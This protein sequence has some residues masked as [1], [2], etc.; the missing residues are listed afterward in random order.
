MRTGVSVNI[1]PR[2]ATTTGLAVEDAP[3]PAGAAGRGGQGGGG[4]GAQNVGRWHWDS[5]TIVSP[6]AARRLYFAGERVYRSDN[7]G[8]S[9]TAVSGD[10][11]RN[12]D[13][14][15]IPIMDKVWPADSVAYMEATTRLSTITALDE[16]PLLEGLLYAGTDDG[17]IHVSDDGGKTWRKV[18][19]ASLTAAGAPEFTY[20]TD[21]QA[22][23]RDVNTVFAALNDWNRGNFTP[24]LVKS[25]DR[26]RTWTSI[27]GDLPARSGAWSIVQDGVNGNL[28]FAGMEFGL[29]ATVDGGAHWIKMAGVPTSQVRD[30]AIQK[31]EGDLVAGTFGRGVFILDDYTALRDVTPQ[32]LGD[33]ARLYPMRDAYQY[34]ELG[35]FEASW[36]NTTYPSAP[37]GALMTYSI[38]QAPAGDTKV[39]IQIA[40]DQGKQVRRIELTGDAL[41][42]GLHRAA[43]DLRGDPPAGAAPGG[44]RGG[45][46]GGGG[47]GGRGNAG[48]T[49]AQARY[50]AT[51]GTISGDAFT[52]IGKP[53]SFLV[54]PLAR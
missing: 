40:D 34:N 16:S 7:R 1:R 8:D 35:Q 46:F 23:P 43:W 10:L 53:M 9:W 31:R 25:T 42:P 22:S 6:H 2:P 14:T 33:R 24:Y 29:Y 36:G 4:G 28:M 47:F 38:G 11:T 50:T 52:A 32:A 41:T 17:L 49:V 12:L 18:E 37:Y 44:G 30:I 39:A 13:R 21:L 15:K 48:P 20:V 3:A 54:I 51:I 45:G 5:P 27:S 19:S 26:G